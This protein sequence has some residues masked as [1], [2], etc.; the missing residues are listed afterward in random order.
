M[1]TWVCVYEQGRLTSLLTYVA[2][3]RVV[4]RGVFVVVA[5]FSLFHEEFVEPAVLHAQTDDGGNRVLMV[6]GDDDWSAG[7]HDGRVEV[8]PLTWIATSATNTF[9]S[10]SSLTLS[11]RQFVIQSHVK[12]LFHQSSV[13]QYII[14]SPYTR[15]SITPLL[16]LSI[17]PS[18]IDSISSI[19]TTA[20]VTRGTTSEKDTCCV[21]NMHLTL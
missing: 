17:L 13:H 1:H 18:S 14:L 5:T 11:V 10:S 6:D 16:Y 15:I 19:R 3:T 8:E 9:A 21:I 2:A 4:T 7:C 20:D 12:Q